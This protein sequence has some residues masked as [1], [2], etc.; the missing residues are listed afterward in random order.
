MMNK[1]EPV[2]TLITLKSKDLSFKKM[3]NSL[4]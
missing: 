1:V 2:E 4:N 3:L